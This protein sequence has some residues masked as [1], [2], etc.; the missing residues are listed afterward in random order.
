MFGKKSLKDLENFVF[1]LLSKLD[2]N[3]LYHGR[4][5]TF[6][7]V[8]P[9]SKKLCELENL[10]EEDTSIVKKKLKLKLNNQKKK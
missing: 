7:D 2:K 4:H 10:S 9:T 5:H 3:L 8:Y 6:E 1:D